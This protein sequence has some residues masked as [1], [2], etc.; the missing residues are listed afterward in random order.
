LALGGGD[1][2]DLYWRRK[3]RKRLYY[4]KRLFGQCEK[5]QCEIPQNWSWG[6]DGPGGYW[7]ET[8]LDLMA[9]P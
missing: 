2:D 7:W 4:S 5:S 8:S 1:G 9:R 3:R 6:S